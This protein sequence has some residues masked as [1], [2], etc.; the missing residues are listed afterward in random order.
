MEDLAQQLAGV[1][2]DPGAMAQVQAVLQSLG[3]SQPGTGAQSAPPPSPPPSQ[4][5][6]PP[7]APTA[8]VPAAPNPLA[9]LA[10]SGLDANLLGALTK[11]VPMLSSVQREDDT[12]RLLHALRPLLSEPRQKKLDEA[13]K[14]LRMMRML[15]MLKNTGLLGGL[16]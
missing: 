1:L 8:P 10:G 14:L 4:P 15:P 6:S 9:A 5:A 12:T 11:L 3:G 2:N 13:M 16:L 7:P